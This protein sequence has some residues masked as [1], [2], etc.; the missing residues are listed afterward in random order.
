MVQQRFLRFAGRH[1]IG[2]GNYMVSLQIPVDSA[3]RIREF[4]GKGGGAGRRSFELTRSYYRDNMSHLDHQSG[5]GRG[6]REEP[7][8]GGSSQFFYYWFGTNLQWTNRQ[9]RVVH[10]Y[11]G[12]QRAVDVCFNRFY[13][14]STLLD[15]GDG[16]C[17][18]DGGEN[19]HENKPVGNLGILS[20]NT[21]DGLSQRPQRTPKSHFLFVGRRFAGTGKNNRQTK[22]PIGK[23]KGPYGESVSLRFSINGPFSLLSVSA[24][25]VRDTVSFGCGYAALASLCPTEV[26]PFGSPF[27]SGLE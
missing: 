14:L 9:G 27:P 7:G 17:L 11:P 21:N 4:R 19:Q 22:R 10:Y 25:S 26:V 15:M 20:S 23:T 6:S 2:W 24:N 5:T 3:P 18:Q 13:Y 12:D 16:R 8:G 1:R